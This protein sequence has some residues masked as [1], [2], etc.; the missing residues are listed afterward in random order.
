[1]MVGRW[2]SFWD[3]LFLGT[4][5]NFKGEI[6]RQHAIYESYQY[7]WWSWDLP[8]SLA[9]KYHISSHP[10]PVVKQIWFN[11]S[12]QITAESKCLGHWHLRL[13]LFCPAHPPAL[14]SGHTSTQWQLS[15]LRF[16]PKGRKN[17]WTCQL[18][19]ILHKQ[20]HIYI[21][22]HN[23]K[24]MNETRRSGDG[25]LRISVAVPIIP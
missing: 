25:S 12:R 19:D 17:L 8:F 2:V 1:M 23:I 9:W 3:C 6:T 20:F 16:R 15:H 7:W 14:E 10:S 4:M 13:H 18:W 24:P 11:Q 21:Y 22:I 5:L